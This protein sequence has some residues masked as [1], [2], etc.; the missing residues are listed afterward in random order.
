MKDRIDAILKREQAEYLDALLPP[1]ETLLR[2]MEAV[3]AERGIPI[4]DREVG[5][6]L[7]LLAASCGAR[8]MLE[9]GTAI[10][11]GSICL[12]RGAAEAAVV[13]LDRDPEIL[14]EAKRWL[15]RAGVADRVELLRGDALELLPALDGPFELAYIDADKL[16]LR[17]Y[18]DLLLPKL[19]VGGLVVV[20]NLLW[21]GRVAGDELDEETEAIRA[22]NG[23]FM[24]HPQLDSVLLPLGDGVGLATKTRPLV[25]ELGGPF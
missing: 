1:S 10:G 19:A 21:K 25:T 3:A 2:E 12:A 20:D 14:A 23:Y 13:S 18:L 8:R 17:R 7:G 24:M 22:F 15:E 9:I 16:R 6:L 11:Y 5:R 4:S